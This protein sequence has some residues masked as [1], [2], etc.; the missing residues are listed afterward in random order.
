MGYVA[1]TVRLESDLKKQFD[2]V[3]KSMGMNANVA[4]NIF[5]RAVV[6]DKCIPFA[7]ES[8]EKKYRDDALAAFMAIRQQAEN[9]TSP[10]ISDEEIE[11]EISSYRSGQ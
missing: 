4:M 1:T 9:S 10:E 7:V 6:R 8:P 2:A 5:V 11:K 3:C